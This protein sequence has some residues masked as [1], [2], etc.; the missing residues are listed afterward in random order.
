MI[1]TPVRPF[2]TPRPRPRLVRVATLLAAAGVLGVGSADVALAD[3][4]CPDPPPTCLGRR[5]TLCG[6]PGNDTILGSAA[7]DV[8][9]GSGGNDTIRARGGNDVLCG[10][11]G[12]DKLFGSN[13]DDVLS[14]DEGADELHGGTGGDIL[15]GGQGSDFLDGGGGDDVVR[16]GRGTDTC[17]GGM[18]LGDVDKGDCETTL[19]IPR[20]VRVA[21]PFGRGALRP[22]LHGRA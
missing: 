15:R 5:A 12:D 21:V 18:S 11:I 17:D 1:P 22:M 19:R 8:V 10:N 16:G 14:G 7:D 2:R 3:W 20:A 4:P 6:T 9:V 13:G